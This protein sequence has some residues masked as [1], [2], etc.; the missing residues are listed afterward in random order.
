M[1]HVHQSE[2]FFLI[3]HACLSFT[4]AS[5]SYIVWGVWNQLLIH[6]VT[7]FYRLSCSMGD[8]GLILDNTVDP[9][10][11]IIWNCT[12][13]MSEVNLNS[14]FTKLSVQ[15]ITILTR[16]QLLAIRPTWLTRKK[17]HNQVFIHCPSVSCHIVSELCCHYSSPKLNW[18]ELLQRSFT[19]ICM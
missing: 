17:K 18:I 10:K 8:T 2:L 11:N 15:S 6:S 16:A 4:T 5:K 19:E 1:L 14:W 9:L 13:H 12:F 3:W 7:T